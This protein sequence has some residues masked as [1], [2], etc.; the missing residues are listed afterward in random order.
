MAD[1]HSAGVISCGD[2]AFA[3]CMC[4]VFAGMPATT[5]MVAEYAAN[6]HLIDVGQRPATWT[7]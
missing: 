1:K 6:Q 5:R 7:S 4:G 2:V 3:D